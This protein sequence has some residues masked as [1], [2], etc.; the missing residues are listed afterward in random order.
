MPAI[1]AVAM[2]SPLGRLPATIASNAARL[3]VTAPRARA[4]R[5][6]MD[7]AEISTIRA[8][9]RGPRWVSLAAF[10]GPAR[11]VRPGHRVAHP[12][13][14][15]AR[16]RH[17]RSRGHRSDRAARRA[18]RPAGPALTT[19]TPAGPTAYHRARGC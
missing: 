19:L 2:T 14:V 3:I 18:A 1:R 13:G 15:S 8:S 11:E 4:S 9:P 5:R 6:V 7:L 12:S 17:G 10:T 16:Q